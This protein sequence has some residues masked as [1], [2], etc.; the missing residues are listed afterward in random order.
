MASVVGDR[1]NVSSSALT[2]PSTSVRRTVRWSEKEWCYR[3]VDPLPFPYTTTPQPITA[4]IP[5]PSP[6]T[7][8]TPLPPHQLE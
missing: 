4:F 1:D 6:P 3:S 8:W 5:S 7:R 2:P